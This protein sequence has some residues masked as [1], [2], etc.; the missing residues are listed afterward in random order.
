MFTF[1]ILLTLIFL[2]PLLGFLFVQRKQMPE[3]TLSFFLGLAA[4]TFA[5]V[6]IFEASGELLPPTK[7]G[8]I[9]LI[10]FGAGVAANFFLDQLLPAHEHHQ[11]HQCEHPAKFCHLTTMT[12]ISL[13]WHNLIEGITFGL[14]AAG[15]LQATL[16]L[17]VMIVLHNLPL[18]LALIAPETYTHR[19]LKHILKHLFF[20]NITFVIGASSYFWLQQNLDEFFLTNGEFFAFGMITYLLIHEIWPV[21]QQ[22]NGKKFAWLGALSGVILI[23]LLEFLL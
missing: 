15:D 1:L 23:I 9:A 19:S 20:A 14:L 10:F 21:A 22:K 13:S 5:T 4:G 17:T 12:T 18:N 16:I 8:L 6:V 7:I 3:K 2:S 11:H